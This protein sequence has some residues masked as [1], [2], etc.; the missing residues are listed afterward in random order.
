MTLSIAITPII[1][2][3]PIF[4]AVALIKL[5]LWQRNRNRTEAFDNSDIAR[6]PG[7]SLDQKINDLIFDLNTSLM[8]VLICGGV[9][10]FIYNSELNLATKSLTYVLLTIYMVPFLR[11]ARQQFVELANYRNGSKGEKAV[12][13][14]LSELIRYNWHVFHDVPAKGFNIDHVIVGPKGV[15]AIETKYRKKLK[16]NDGHRVVFNGQQLNFP[17]W[18]EKKPLEQALRQSKWIEKELTSSTGNTVNVGS[19]LALPGWYVERTS[20]KCAVSVMN[21]KLLSNP[22]SFKPVQVLSEAQIKAI[23]HQLRN[24]Q[25]SS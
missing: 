23:C 11:K 6:Y 7:Q 9:L 21:H 10:A 1:V 13:E 8:Q 25:K 14:C 2:L 12:G 24:L 19:V 17:N 18:I 15:F 16:A 22:N 4:L 20:G 3:A 5:T